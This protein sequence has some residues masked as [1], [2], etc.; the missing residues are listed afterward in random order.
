[1]SV[2]AGAGLDLQKLSTKRAQDCRES[3]ICTSIL[4]LKNDVRVTLLEDQVGKICSESSVSPNKKQ[5]KLALS[6]QREIIPTVSAA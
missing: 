6:E 2:S 5:N 4:F 3:S 1:M